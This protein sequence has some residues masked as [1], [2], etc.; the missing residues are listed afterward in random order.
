MTVTR[1]LLF[2]SAG[3]LCLCVDA[4]GRWSVRAHT[5]RTGARG[6]TAKRLDGIGA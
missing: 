1:A 2:F 6:L 5:L 3:F 4:A